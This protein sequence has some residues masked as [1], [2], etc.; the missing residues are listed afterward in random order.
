[1]FVLVYAKRSLAIYT[2]SAHKGTF[3]KMSPKHLQRYVDEFT[4]RHNLREFD[5]I[6]QMTALIRRMAR[7]RLKYADLIADN[8]LPSGAR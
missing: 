6:Q 4:G 5:T 2:D 7:K 8:G 3:H 1:M